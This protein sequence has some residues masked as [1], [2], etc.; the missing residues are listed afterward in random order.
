MDSPAITD[1]GDTV[2]TL[3]KHSIRFIQVIFVFNI[4][5]TGVVGSITL[6]ATSKAPQLVF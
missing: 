5:V 6:F 1:N 3:P 2:G 4:L